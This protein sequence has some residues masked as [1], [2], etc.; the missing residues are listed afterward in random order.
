MKGR[1]GGE[2]KKL[3]ALIIVL[4][5]VLIPASGH[6]KTGLLD[7]SLIATQDEEEDD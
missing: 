3:I 5:F 6:G 1:I 7:F 2:M 4:F